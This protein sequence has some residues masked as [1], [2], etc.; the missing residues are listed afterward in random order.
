M[1]SQP[2]SDEAGTD[3]V[4]LDSDRRIA[5][6]Q[7]QVKSEAKRNMW[8]LIVGFVLLLVAL[9]IPDWVWLHENFE[10]RLPAICIAPATIT[11]IGVIYTLPSPGS[12]GF[13]SPFIYAAVPLFGSVVCA[14]VGIYGL[15][16][17]E[18]QHRSRYGRYSCFSFLFAGATLVVFAGCYTALIFVP[19]SGEDYDACGPALSRPDWG[20]AP[21]IGGFLCLACVAYWTGCA[22]FIGTRSHDQEPMVEAQSPGPRISRPLDQGDN[23]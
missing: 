10:K 16:R 6:N 13:P 5:E 23:L 4:R 7:A 14:I 11:N 8:V 22:G 1:L 21:F 15:S 20:L 2:A 19:V 9:V 17:Q 3:D 12:P 18:V